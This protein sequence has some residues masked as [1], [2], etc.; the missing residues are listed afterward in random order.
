[1]GKAL[2]V[3]IASP[4]LR[5]LCRAAADGLN[6]YL[7]TH[8]DV[9]PAVVERFEPWHFLA[10][11]MGMHVSYLGFAQA[12]L[13]SPRKSTEPHDGSNAWA[14][15]PSRSAS[16]TAPGGSRS[17]VPTARA[18]FTFGRSETSGGPRCSHP[19]PRCR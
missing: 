18:W 13:A 14:I 2:I 17:C 3:W 5:A 11:Q 12:Q 6:W 10:Q 16:A 8:P 4:R 7:A 9:Q 19:A 1:M 15:A